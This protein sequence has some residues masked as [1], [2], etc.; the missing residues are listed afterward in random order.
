VRVLE[1]ARLQLEGR[2]R[3]HM[4]VRGAWRDSLLYAALS[5]FPSV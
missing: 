1:K 4:W 3:D 2:L 5:S